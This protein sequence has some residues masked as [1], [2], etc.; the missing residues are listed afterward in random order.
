M[1]DDR[2]YIGVSMGLDVTDL[3]AGLS[4]ANKQ[5]QLANSEFKAA[6]S[7]MDD[8]S[9]SV[10]GVSAKVK[11][12]DTVLTAQ[13][14]KLA[15]LTAEYEK[16][17]K[18]Q[19]EG[20][21]AARKLKVQIN[22]QQAV[23]NKTQKEFD[24]YSE[25]L[26]EA[27]AGNLDLDKVSLR[28]GKAVEKTGESAE[29]AGDGFTV[30]KGAIAGFIANGLTA[31]ISKAIEASTSLLNL[32]ES[33]REFRTDMAILST[34]AERVGVSTETVGAAMK[35]LSGIIDETDSSVE[36]LS[37]LMQ[38]GFSENTLGTAV[39]TLSNAIVAF[40]D[41]LKIES[42]SDSLQETIQQFELGN[43][44]TGQFAELLERLGYNLD[45]VKE[46]YG[47]LSTAEQKQAYLLGLVDK[48]LGG[49]A[50]KYREQNA[51]LVT[52]KETQYDYN[53]EM[54]ELGE[55]MEPI[56]AEIAAFKVQLAKELAPTLKN[57]VLPALSD[58]LDKLEES[59][60]ITKF[61]NALAWI[62]EN[63]ED[64]AKSVYAAVLVWKTFTAVLAISNT[65]RAVTTATQGM[66]TA[67][68]AATVAQ[69]GLN[70]AMNSNA[71]GAILSVVGLLAGG[72]LTLSM[73]NKDVE[74]TTEETTR[75]LTEAEKAA[76]DLAEAYNE[77]KTAADELAS[78]ENANLDYTQTLWHELANLTD[79]NGKVKEGYE[80][81]AEFILNELNKALDT[82]YTMTG[83]VINQYGEMKKA[84]EDVILA[85]RAQIMLEAYEES[86][87]EAIKSTAEAEKARATQAQEIAAQ[88]E[89]YNQK[90]QEYLEYKALYE[91]KVADA[92]THND[93]VAL[94]GMER[95]LNSLK[96]SADTEK[97]TL[98]DK[99]AKYDETE[100]LLYGYYSDIAGY[101]KA[102]T[103]ILEGE[104]D[105]A[106]EY[107]GNLGNGF[108]TVASTAKLSADEQKKVLEQQVI[109]TEVNARLMKEA[110][111]QGVDGVSEE[112]VATA[113]EQARKAKD[114]F[115][116][117]GGDITK[118]IA[119]GAED[120]EWT[121]SGAM[122]RLVNK[123]VTAAKNA[124][125]IESP[126][127]LMRK[128]VGQYL[129]KGIGVGVLDS[130][131][132][133][134]KD[135]EKFNDFMAES[136]GGGSIG[137]LTSGISAGVSAVKNNSVGGT[138]KA[139]G[140]SSS[141]VT[142]VNAGLTVHYNGALSRKQLKQQENDY[143]AAIKTKLKAEGLI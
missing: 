10:E 32:A 83:N 29:K 51:E 44:A 36:A 43:N 62:V 106:I 3:K 78:A 12:L 71:F 135:I 74:E 61:G 126:S 13:K 115:Y 17:A 55:I 31:L 64:I 84:I 142:T 133:V 16:V 120:E 15:G 35:S 113:E 139:V 72:L 128:E 60:A 122:E 117:V 111:E 118:G 34:N 54:A 94:E 80:G 108:Q 103:L 119:E 110:Y 140:G 100:T 18:E 59:G 131:P 99:Q 89:V 24:N 95:R 49:V 23:V 2:N 21:E 86:Y 104:T 56:S 58:F 28:A 90:Q 5:I 68:S 45:T 92:Q 11:Q 20:S 121:L 93:R 102:S 26:K 4:E 129:G 138:V 38:A 7:G 22:N 114:E 130:I 134:E 66:T 30:A 25:T 52:A 101:E 132:S 65:I 73:R 116:A 105:K 63:F 33:T 87:R 98:D 8:W 14:S 123:A 41:T 141:K 47:E 70:A 19:G 112:M 50:Q 69:H 77:T 85:K 107:L 48:K 136:L 124:A 82:E 39:E 37:N 127:K 53:K 42:L 57:R 67:I 46:E 125:I 6:S 88:Q 40:P 76:Q 79:A 96:I 81:R 143:Y 137:D 1:P 75:E 109:D 97:A 91:Q 27:K 9:K